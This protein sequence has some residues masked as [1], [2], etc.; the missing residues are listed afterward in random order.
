MKIEHFVRHKRI[1]DSTSQ[2]NWNRHH[3]DINE[4]CN[5]AIWE[6]VLS[7]SVEYLPITV[8]YVSNIFEIARTTAFQKNIYSYENINRRRY[9]TLSMFIDGWQLQID[10]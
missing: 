10:F 7:S 3:R 9:S 1:F 6:R 4:F 2:P 8:V 5:L